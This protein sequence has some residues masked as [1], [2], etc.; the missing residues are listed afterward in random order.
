VGDPLVEGVGDVVAG[1]LEG[2]GVLPAL[3]DQGVD[4]GGDDRRRR[5]PAEVGRQQRRRRRR[6][7]VRRVEALEPVEEGGVEGQRG[8]V[9]LDRLQALP[10]R[11]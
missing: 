11:A 3:T 10:L 7:W 6:G 8:G 5:Q 4:L 2:V 9:L 1:R